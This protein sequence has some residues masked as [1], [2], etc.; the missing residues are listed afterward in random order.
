MVTV[1]SECDFLNHISCVYRKPKFLAI[2]TSRIID[3][4]SRIISPGA[5]NDLF[6]CASQSIT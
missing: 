1:S 3:L 2:I 5:K 6:I 4:S